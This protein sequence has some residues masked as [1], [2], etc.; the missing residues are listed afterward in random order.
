M[1]VWRS[2]E[3]LESPAADTPYT[4]DSEKYKVLEV[5][6]QLWSEAAVGKRLAYRIFIAGV[7]RI[8]LGSVQSNS[9]MVISLCVNI[10]KPVHSRRR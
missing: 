1:F 10:K 7:P 6:N 3:S 2:S 5:V 8:S 9:C 4:P